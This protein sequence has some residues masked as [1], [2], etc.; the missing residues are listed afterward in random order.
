MIILQRTGKGHTREE[1]LLLFA[2]LG[3]NQCQF[4]CAEDSDADFRNPEN[5]ILVT[6]H[7]YV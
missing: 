2:T 4:L 7:I 3:E 5:N 6:M 1:Q